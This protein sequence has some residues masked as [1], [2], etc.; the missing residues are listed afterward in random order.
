[1]KDA[2]LISILLDRSGSMGSIKDDTIGGYNNFLSQ[3]QAI[4]GDCTLTLTQFD[5]GG[6][7]IVH[8][9]TPIANVPALNADT[10]QPRGGTPLLDAL[11]KT[12][13]STGSALKAIPEDKRPDKIVFVIITDGEENSSHEYTKAQIKEMIEHQETLYKWNFVFL[14]ANQDAFA[15]ARSM[16]I[17]SSKAAGFA[18]NAMGVNA[19]Y[20]N[21][22]SNVARYRQ[23]GPGGQS[24]MLDWSGDQRAEMDDSSNAAGLKKKTAKNRK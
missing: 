8:E 9:N 18:G 19:L 15:E 7:D 6:I 12:I 3:Q 20:A 10:Y 5:T 16:G 14:G 23:S 13:K 2:T 4:P 1:M 24:A 11:G 21:V 22:A 17:S